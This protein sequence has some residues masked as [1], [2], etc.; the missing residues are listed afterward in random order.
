M[1]GLSG[2][3]KMLK[4]RGGD[5]LYARERE[6]SFNSIITWGDGKGTGKT[7]GWV[8]RITVSQ[9]PVGGGNYF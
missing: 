3:A 4:E 8:I 2:Y 9:V 1:E 7:V 6:Q 5:N